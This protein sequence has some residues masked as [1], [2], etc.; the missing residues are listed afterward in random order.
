MGA[1]RDVA[2]NELPIRGAV[3]NASTSTTN[4][5]TLVASDSGCIFINK[6]ATATTYTLPAVADAAGKWFWFY[7]VGAAGFVISAPS[8]T[9]V[10]LND[11]S[12]TTASFAT[13]SQMIGAAAMVFCD[14]TNYLLFNLSAGAVT[15]TLA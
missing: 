4:A 9:L 15:V 7:N 10:G 8:G 1:T 13:S 2:L 12:N 3:I 5:F 6:D 14:G 11:A